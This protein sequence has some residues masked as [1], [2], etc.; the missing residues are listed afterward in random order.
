MDRRGF[1]RT[2]AGAAA[3]Q[4]LSRVC[5]QSV[6][7]PNIVLLLADDLGYGDVGSYGSRLPTPNLDRMAGEGVRFTQ[8]YSAS[9]LCSPSRAALLTGRYPTRV[10]IHTVLFP[11]GDNGLSPSETSMARL[12]KPLNYDTTC[13]GKWHLGSAPQYAPA[14]H[15]FDRFFGVPYSN[16]MTPLPLME[17]AAVLET[18][19][20]NAMLTQRYTQRAVE[21]IANSGDRPFFMYVG[22][23]TPHIPVGVSAPFRGKSG[24]GPYGDAV[25]EMDWSVG[26]ILDALAARGVENNT[27]VIFTSDNGPWYQGSPG[28]LRGRKGETYEGGMREPF[29]ARF[30][31][32]IPGGSVS[33]GVLSLMDLVPTIAGLTGAGSTANPVDGIDAWPLFTGEKS[34]LDRNALLFFD[35]WDIQC[36]RL[37]QWKLHFAR[38][39]SPPWIEDPASGRYNLP[40][41]PMELYDIESD[42]DESYECSAQNPG[43]VAGILAQVQS[44]ISTFPIQVQTAWNDTR[45]RKAACAATGARP[46]LRKP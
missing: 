36:A 16:D 15:G 42:P 27:L 31:G 10:G 19:T 34:S 44:Q 5:G 8:C 41:D 39:N 4:L 40:L 29:L 30:P 35:S 28:R 13:I 24:R 21:T 32:R 1:L 9:G 18:N 43:V 46:V 6:S 11:G 25:M 38:D 23:N 20:S 3:G 14:N 37:G 2:A 26:Q 12:L 33:N 22:Y 7:P 45:T 17:G